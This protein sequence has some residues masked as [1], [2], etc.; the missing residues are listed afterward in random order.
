MPNKRS[1]YG[2]MLDR[3]QPLVL[4]YVVG[5]GSWKDNNISA[6]QV[7]KRNEITLKEGPEEFKEIIN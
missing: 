4:N 5:G 1:K 3:L 7:Y 2:A 6:E